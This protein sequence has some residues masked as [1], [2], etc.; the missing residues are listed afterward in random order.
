MTRQEQI[1][2]ESELYL[3]YAKTREQMLETRAL[4]VKQRT[5]INAQLA[6]LDK[7]L[8]ARKIAYVEESRALHAQPIEEGNWWKKC[9]KALR[10]YVCGDTTELDE[11]CAKVIRPTDEAA[12]EVEQPTEGGG[13]L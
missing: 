8:R 11:I 5:E 9:K 4:L 12:Q 1:Q 2:R 3:D 6:K 13:E 7:E 10:S